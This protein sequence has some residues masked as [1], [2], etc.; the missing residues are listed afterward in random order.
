LLWL[1]FGLMIVLFAATYAYSADGIKECVQADGSIMYT[2]KP[3]LGCTDLILPGL[4]IIPERTD[5]LQPSIP[6]VITAAPQVA[7]KSAALTEACV[8]YHEWLTINMRTMGGFE[9]NS[10][11][12]T[13]R[14]LLLTKLFGSGFS[15][16]G[17]S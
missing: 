4:S 15:P 12:D 6:P 17:C 3:Q 13:K 11:D 7:P 5:Y 16:Y 2:N 9:Y 8:L 10:V 1:S 14:R